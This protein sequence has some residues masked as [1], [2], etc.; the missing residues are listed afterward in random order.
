MNTK[1]IGKPYTVTFDILTRFIVKYIEVSKNLLYFHTNQVY[2][3]V[4]VQM[5]ESPISGEI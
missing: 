1:V 2:T 5:D 4:K 3:A